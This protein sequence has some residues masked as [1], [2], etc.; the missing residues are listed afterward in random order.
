M[1][2]T[3]LPPPPHPHQYSF[4]SFV[5]NNT[6]FSLLKYLYKPTKKK[7]MKQGYTSKFVRTLFSIT[8]L[9]HPQTKHK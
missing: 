7:V 1:E 9:F 4:F 2:I 5:S 8:L 3:H 6:F